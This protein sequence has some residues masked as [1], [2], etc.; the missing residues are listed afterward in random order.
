MEK[1][2]AFH[3]WHSVT[4]RGDDDDVQKNYG[5]TKTML[6]IHKNGP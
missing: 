2:I 1:E 5:E 6:M 4:D 3:R